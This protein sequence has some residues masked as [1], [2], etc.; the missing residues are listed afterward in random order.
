[1]AK[2]IV[3]D[4]LTQEETQTLENLRKRGV[5]IYAAPIEI[6]HREQLTTLGIAWEQCRSWYIGSEKVT[7]HL[8][9]ADE[10]TYYFLLGELR[11]R[12]RN[13]YRS[14][15]CQIPGK[16]K[17]LIMCPECNRCSE[18]PYPEIRDKHDA[19]II[20][21]DS[22]IESGSEG[23]TD[24]RMAEQLQ[25]KL[26]YEEIR[27]LMDAENPIITQ[28]FEMKERDGYSTAEIADKLCLTPR[29]V[30]YYLSRAK[31]IG[32]KYNKES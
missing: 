13:E 30:Y 19:N 29:N 15:R 10:A 25:A 31:A 27:R 26:E 32:Q 16:N 7:V 9:P 3:W 1:M 5:E 28:V 18:C 20:S 12:H 11:T 23:E 21:W 8:T 14:R 6:E 2:E 17:P 22:I 4:S 24:N